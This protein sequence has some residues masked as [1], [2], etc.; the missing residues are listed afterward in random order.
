MTNNST[1]TNNN[2]NKGLTLWLGGT[3]SLCRTYINQFGTEGLLLCGLESTPP[4]WVKNAYVQCDLTTLTD[5][6]ATFLLERYPDI[7]TIVIGVRPLLFAPYTHNTGVSEN[8]LRGI[9]VLL[10]HACTRLENLRFVL[11]ISSVA[12]ADHLRSQHFVSEETSSSS[13]S[14]S[15]SSTNTTLPPPLSEYKAPY[16][17]FKRMSEDVITEICEQH[18]D[19]VQCCHIRL[20]AIF[21]DTVS[22]IQCS[23]LDLQSRI[24]CYL[25]LAIDSNSSLNVSRAIHAILGRSSESSADEAISNNIQSLYYYTRPLALERP[26]PY[27]Y[28]LQ[29]FRNAYQLQY[30]SIWIP[31]WIVTW[32]VAAVHW[33]AYWNARCFL[34][35]VPYIDAADYLLQ[36]AS[37]EHSFDCSRFGRDFPELQEESIL[38][39]FERRRDFLKRPKSKTRFFSDL[40]FKR[41]T[42]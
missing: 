24:G 35:S 41:K 32:F 25:P 20:S 23:A 2:N 19:R 29:E 12:A 33:L 3:S 10:S 21:S 11:H 26:V 40:G 15:S 16:D 42:G 39:C 9:Q 8:M 17:R 30:T 22:C 13:S 38:E 36:V 28:Y 6:Q 37:R 34:G 31:V 27:G 4:E 18:H 14:S 5:Q 1:T 7:S